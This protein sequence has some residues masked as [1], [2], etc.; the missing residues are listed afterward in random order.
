MPRS[1]AFAYLEIYRGWCD[2]AKRCC[3]TFETAWFPR[4]V[5]DW[6]R[7]R[8]E[9]LMY[10]DTVKVFGELCLFCHADLVMRA[11]QLN[12][13][14]DPLKKAD[15]IKGIADACGMDTD[16]SSVVYAFAFGGTPCRC[17]I[18]GCKDPTRQVA[19]ALLKAAA[20]A[21]RLDRTVDLTVDSDSDDE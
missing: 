11:V 17:P 21:R 18:L 2:Q 12:S 14:F 16:V 15:V 4:S 9:H 7:A 20:Q 1:L 3:L 19:V 10:S 13:T 5:W 8:S 6:A